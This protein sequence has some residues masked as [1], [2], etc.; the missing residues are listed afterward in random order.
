[1]IQRNIQL[2]ATYRL[3][4]FVKIFHV[5]DPDVQTGSKY[6]EIIIAELRQ[7]EGPPSGAS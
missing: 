6:K 5:Y 1:M 4:S 7:P 2:P 3:S